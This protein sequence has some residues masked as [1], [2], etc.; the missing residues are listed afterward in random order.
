M[1]GRPLF[2]VLLLLASA[3]LNAAPL[4]RVDEQ[5]LPLPV[6]ELGEP[7]FYGLARDRREEAYRF[8]WQARDGGGVILS[9][10]RLSD[11]RAQLSVREFVG[12]LNGWHR[13]H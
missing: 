13:H 5:A 3:Q 2:G 4:P 10:K 11:G 6:T 8:I 1:H 7:S 12:E 9:V